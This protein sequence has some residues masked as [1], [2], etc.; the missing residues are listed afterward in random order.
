[1]VTISVPLSKEDQESLDHL[2]KSGVASN[3]AAVMRKALVRLAE[4]EA[5][6]DVLR[7]EREIAQGKVLKGDIKTLL[8]L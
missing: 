2:V 4:E 8:E 3:R 5:V 1:M 6:E 7:A